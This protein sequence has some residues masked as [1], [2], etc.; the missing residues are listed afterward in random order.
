METPVKTGA[1]EEVKENGLPGK[2]QNRWEVSGTSIV[3]KLDF[4][5]MDVTFQSRPSNKETVH[6]HVPTQDNEFSFTKNESKLL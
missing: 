6:W 2:K 3:P 5:Y 1:S 4:K